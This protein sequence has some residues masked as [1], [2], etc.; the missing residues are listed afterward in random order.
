MEN[1]GNI[2][3]NKIFFDDDSLKAKSNL[4]LAI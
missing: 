2:Q 3:R 1:N 4:L